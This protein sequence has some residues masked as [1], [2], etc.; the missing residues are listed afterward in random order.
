MDET[1]LYKLAGWAIGKLKPARA[2]GIKESIQITGQL[3]YPHKKIHMALDN[4]VQIA[5]LGACR[6]E[7][8]TVAWIE[9]NMRPG[10][11]FFD[12]GANVGAYAFVADTVAGGNCD[13]YAFE[14]SYSTFAALVANVRLNR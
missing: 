3:D 1:R 2:V 8:E 4:A 11:V 9:S 14:P 6:K 5:R 12:V 7:P 13:I 10:D